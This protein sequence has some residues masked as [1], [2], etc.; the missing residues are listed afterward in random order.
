[1]KLRGQGDLLG[2]RQAGVP[3]FRVANLATDEAMLVTAREKAVD[4]TNGLDLATLK[5]PNHWIQK[6]LEQM[7]KND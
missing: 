1:L 2:T 4:V 3:F 5:N 7:P 6:Y